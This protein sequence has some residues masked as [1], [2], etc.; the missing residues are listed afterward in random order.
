MWLSIVLNATQQKIAEYR[1]T[2]RYCFG[3]MYVYLNCN[4]LFYE[5]V[6]KMDGNV[7]QAQFVKTFRL[8]H[9]TGVDLKATDKINTSNYSGILL[10]VFPI[11]SILTYKDTLHSCW[12]SATS[13]LVNKLH[14]SIKD[15]IIT[16]WLKTHL[17]LWY[18]YKNLRLI[19][20]LYA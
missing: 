17:L 7:S 3:R 12:I 2:Y 14:H 8:L 16:L 1:S 19:F 9:E 15:T 18:R 10:A 13:Y 4:V 20:S 5:F 11:P 6:R